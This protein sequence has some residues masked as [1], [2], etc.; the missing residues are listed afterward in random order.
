VT[1]IPVPFKLAALMN[2]EVLD[3]RCE[4]GILALVLAILIFGPLAFGAVPPAA[5][6]VIQGLTLVILVLWGVR[7]WL[8]PR[9]QLLWTPIC[10][11]V[12]AF[13][14]Y[15][16]I[17]YLAADIE[18]VARQELIRV[19]VY[20]LLFLTVLNNLNRQEAT[21]AI[22]FVLIFLAMVLSFH[23]VYQFLTGSNRIWNV[24]NTAYPHR[25]S[26]TYICPNHLGGFL[27]MVLPL[28]LAYTLASRVKPVLRVFLGYASL[29]IMAGIVVTLSRGSW[30]ST[31]LSLVVFFGVLLFQRG[32][33]L[34]SL[35]LLAVILG[36][37]GYFLSGNYSLQARIRKAD[38]SRVKQDTR[39]MLWESALKIWQED[40]WWGVG[41]AH[42]DYR[43]RQYRPELVQQ[44]PAWA[45]NDVLN[46][47]ADWGVAGTC[48][49]AAA[50]GLLGLGVVKTWASV[51]GSANDLRGRKNSNKFAFV[52]GAS[53]GLFA[54]L[55]HS[56][57]DFNMHIPANAVLAVTLMALLSSHLRFATERYWTRAGLWVRLAAT[58]VLLAGTIYF[59]Q[60]GWRHTQEYRNLR[61]AAAAP[62]FSPEKVGWLKKAYAVEPMNPETTFEI[63]EAY[64]IQSS[65]GGDNY[66]ALAT[67]AMDWFGRTM[68]LNRWGGYGYLRYGW[69]LD[70]LDRSA[71]SERYFDR[72]EELDPNGYFTLANIGLHYV[73]IGDYAAAK[74]WFERSLRLEGPGNF[75]SRTYLEIAN[76]RLLEAATNGGTGRLEAPTP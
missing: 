19:L 40:I 69:C 26:G 34:A 29:T 16:I 33:R 71:E 70:W 22:S 50:W 42:Y 53:V 13:V 56:T 8:Q 47:L 44:R 68:K 25:A 49:V 67:Q 5:F 51:R 2:R 31:A 9:P 11:A 54:I 41:P 76:S 65:E 73:Q 12:A 38:M 61:Q 57:C 6:L 74:P 1:S 7:M 27:E 21:Q 17:R 43:F 60:Q 30:L 14:V 23:A 63:G 45:H 15:A 39:L 62:N 37:A 64:R 59:G 55:V 10:W 75:I 36:G 48:L 72:A 28:G 4:L 24:V 18:Y 66:R 32:H 46:A 35:A 20:A 52:L 3:R 58:A